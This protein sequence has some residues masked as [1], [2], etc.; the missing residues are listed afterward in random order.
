[1]GGVFGESPERA[2]VLSDGYY[3]EWDKKITPEIGEYRIISFNHPKQQ[4][5]R[6]KNLQ[7][8]WE[9]QNKILIKPWQRNFFELNHAH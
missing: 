4:C 6:R 3:M 1:M 9:E 8:H 7:Y 2:L 5:R